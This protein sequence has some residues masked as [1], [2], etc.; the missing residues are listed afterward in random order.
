[1][2]DTG[3]VRLPGIAVRVIVAGDVL[4]GTGALMA[5]AEPSGPGVNF[6]AGAFFLLG[7]GV[8]GAGL[9]LGIAAAVVWL[10]G[11]KGDRQ[12]PAPLLPWQE[13]LRRLTTTAIGLCTIG[14]VVLGAGPL[15]FRGAPG[16]GFERDIPVFLVGIGI[17]GAGLLAGVPPAL[18]WW[19]KRRAGVGR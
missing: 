8:A 1:M 4:L 7:L 2:S 3:Q 5:I 17:S 9:L 19:S 6:G 10:R 12:P 16:T 14:A 15:F 18:Y 11:K 13:R